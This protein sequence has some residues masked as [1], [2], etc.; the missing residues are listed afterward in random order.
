MRVGMTQLWPLSAALGVALGC[1][2]VQIDVGQAPNPT[3]VPLA[4]PVASPTPTTP[5]AGSTFTFSVDGQPVTIE[6][7]P[8]PETYYAQ[9]LAAHG[10]DLS[11]CQAKP[12][13]GPAACPKPASLGSIELRQHVNVELILDASGSM[14][15]T[16][17]GQTKLDA[18]KR[19]LTAFLPTLPSNA[20]VALRVYGHKGS[21]ADVDKPASCA[22]SE[23]LYPFQQLDAAKFQTAIESFEPTGWT[24]L[25]ASFDN[26]LKDFE[27]FEPATSSNFVYVVTDGIETCDGDPV[28]SARGLNSASVHPIVN[29]VGFD[30]D[31][32]AS[33]Q[34]REAAEAGGG[35][36]Y[37]ARN[38]AELNQVFTSNF[39][40]VAWTKYYNCV[41]LSAINQSNSVLVDQTKLYYCVYNLMIAEYYDIDKDT[42]SHYYKLLDAANKA[43][44]AN[45]QTEPVLSQYNAFVG[46]LKENDDYAKQQE[47][48]R[49]DSI[50]ND[51]QKVSEDAINTAQADYNRVVREIS[52]AQ[53]TPKP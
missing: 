24:P 34:L 31:P 37:E 17:G 27:Q 21:N 12:T 28:A 1:R 40:W 49:F 53:N 19:V 39:D 2:S 3:P 51:Q 4:T 26:A 33:A 14:A 41:W 29:I 42:N 10:K 25:A 15:E 11:S 52:D 36:F 46:R 48:R 20:Q 8:S 6:S 13:P 22:S 38:A 18:A 7:L 5:A 23:L 16:I 9:E 32:E 50:V 43:P 30:V 35:K 47:R 44:E 45:K